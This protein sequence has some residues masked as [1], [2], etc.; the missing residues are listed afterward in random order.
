MLLIAG[1]ADEALVVIDGADHLAATTDGGSVLEPTLARLRG[2]AYLQSGRVFDEEAQRSFET[3]LE[4]ARPRGEALE[5]A[6]ALDGFAKLREIT[7]HPSGRD[8]VLAR[9]LF[10]QLGIV[11]APPFATVAGTPGR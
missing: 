10:A 7:S 1:R 11:D 4:L 9:A 8:H 3:A 5:E 6:L 2:W